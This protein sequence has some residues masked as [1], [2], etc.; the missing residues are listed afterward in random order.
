MLYEVITDCYKLFTGPIG[1]H[2]PTFQR[3]NALNRFK[4]DRAV[5]CHDKHRRAIQKFRQTLSQLPLTFRIKPQGRLVQK[6]YPAGLGKDSCQRHL[7]A[8]TTP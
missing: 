5:R 3:N 7:L 1:N 8:L 4:H 2:T 6:Q